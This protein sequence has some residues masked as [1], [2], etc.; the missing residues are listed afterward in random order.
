MRTCYVMNDSTVYICTEMCVLVFIIH[1]RTC[2]IHARLPFLAL[3]TIDYFKA[4]KK[5]N[6]WTKY[7]GP[8]LNST[9]HYEG[10]LLLHWIFESEM[11][12]GG[13]IKPVGLQFF[14]RIWPVFVAV[15]HSM[16]SSSSR[17]PGSPWVSS[18]RKAAA[19]WGI[20]PEDPRGQLG[21][22]KEDG[23]HHVGLVHTLGSWGR[24]KLWHL[25]CSVISL[26]LSYSQ[27]LVGR[28][29]ILSF[30]VDRGVIWLFPVKT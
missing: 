25:S 9:L 30:S 2:E 11:F 20:L 22:W 5:L 14:D 8:F 4:R 26:E 21:K 16:Q 3:L 24:H 13:G 12:S 28:V 23:E 17:L 27:T 7:Q 15:R 19:N 10:F 6:N 18:P 29:L 1:M